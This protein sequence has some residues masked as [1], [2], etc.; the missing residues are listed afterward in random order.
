MRRGSVGRVGRRTV[1][2]VGLSVLALVSACSSDTES[3]STEGS[4]TVTH[5]YGE[6]VVPADPQRVVSVGL[7]EQDTLLALGVVPV[8]VTEWYGEQPDATWPWAHDLLG[9]AR[10][11]VLTQDDGIQFE[12]VTALEPDLIIGTNAGMTQDDYTRLSAIAPTI[13]HSDVDSPYFE[14]WD[15]QTRTIGAALGKPD[16]AEALVENVRTRYREAAEAHPEFAGKK[17]VLLQNAI[18]DGNAIAYQDGLSTDFLTSLGFEIPSELDAFVQEEDAQAY[19]PLENLSV[20]DTADVLLWATESPEDRATLEADPVYSSLQEV[21]ENRLVFTDAITAGAIYFTS[22][23]SL[24]YLLDSLVPAF[25][26][27]LAGAGA[28]TTTAPA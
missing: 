21:R 14:P 25:E 22:P 11:E 2:A 16:E 20:L 23:L 13:A 27:T 7:T 9:D 3:G 15:Q 6:T 10:P 28:A 4:V 12:K 8:G 17:A 18:Y 1:V 19:I 24:P 5:A 26:S